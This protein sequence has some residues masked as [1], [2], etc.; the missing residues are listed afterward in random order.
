MN[1]FRLHGLPFEVTSDRD[2]QFASA[3]WKVFCTLV[4]AKSRLSSGFHPQTN[5]L[6][7]GSTTM[8]PFACCLGY[9]LPI[10]PEE[11]KDVGVPT[12]QALVQ[13]AHRVWK[14][15]RQVL[16]R[17]VETMRRFTDRHRR[18]APSYTVGQKVWLSSKGIPLRTTSPKL[19]PRFIGPFPITRIITITAIQHNLPRLPS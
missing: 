14:R 16:L 12:A 10:F 1:V 8:S 5:G 19:A 4:G 15:A 13:R 11:E 18:P 2:P 3:F 9:Q 6:V 17:N 7:E